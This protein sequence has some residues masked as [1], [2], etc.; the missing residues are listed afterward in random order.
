MPT[1]GKVVKGLKWLALACVAGGIALLGYS[2]SKGATEAG[3]FLVFPVV[4]GSGI[5]AF[6]GTLLIIAGIILGMMHMAAAYP[7]VGG[8]TVPA[9]GP[10]EGSPPT[11]KAGGFL[12]LGPFPVVFGSDKKVTTAM[13]VLAI[14]LTLL[15][16]SFFLFV[17]P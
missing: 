2:A 8:E 16:I 9:S 15:L 5:E 3:L 11:V 6:A 12:L 17:R 4:F 13:L 10:S 7:A 14:V 1:N